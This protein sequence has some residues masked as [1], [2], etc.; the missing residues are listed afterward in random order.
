[1]FL[2]KTKAGSRLQAKNNIRFRIHG[3]TPEANLPYGLVVKAAGN[4][5]E[6]KPLT[7]EGQIEPPTKSKPKERERSRGIPPRLTCLLFPVDD[8]TACFRV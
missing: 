3:L 8:S 2:G 1:M 4:R 7:A 5:Q 6:A